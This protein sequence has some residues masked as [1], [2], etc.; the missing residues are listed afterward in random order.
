MTVQLI[1]KFYR[2]G[3]LPMKALREAT[4]AGTSAVHNRFHRKTRF[5]DEEIDYL[6][7]LY[8]PLFKSLFPELQKGIY[9]T[10]NQDQMQD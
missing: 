3:L 8:W 5:R 10:E 4:G 9:E 2:R 1:E 6:R 7:L